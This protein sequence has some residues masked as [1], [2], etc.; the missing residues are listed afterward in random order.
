MAYSFIKTDVSNTIATIRFDN[1][2]KRNALSAGLITEVQSAIQEFSKQDVRVLILRTDQKHPVWSAGHDISE[3]P[4][5][6]RDPLPADDPLMELL[7][8][9]RAFRAPVI[10]M[11]DGSV[12]GAACDLIMS[13][14]MVIGDKASAFAITPAKL[15][16]PY[17]ASGILH[18][19]SRMPLNIVKE[20]F[21]TALPI[22]AD[23]AAQIGILNAL[24]PEDELEKHTYDMATV[25]ASRSPQAITAFKAQA[26]ML[27][28]A[29]VLSPAT[30]EQLQSIRRNV[31]IGGDYQEGVAAFMENAATS[32]QAT[33]LTIST[34]PSA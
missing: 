31:Y 33:H 8:Q 17:T 3:L 27:A 22:N 9:V 1:Y 7:Q 28:D 34:S 20:M 2:A 13:C 5:A 21:T 19:M 18:F 25:I 24:V 23:R 4:H 30:F 15:G 32:L 26:Q 10:A 6:G 14:D 11:V 12:W 16:L 29:A